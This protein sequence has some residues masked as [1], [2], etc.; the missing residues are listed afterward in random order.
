MAGSAIS[1]GG[2]GSFVNPV[3][4][5]YATSPTTAVPGWQTVPLDTVRFTTVSGMTDLTNHQIVITTSGLYEITWGAVANT[6]SMSSGS[7][8][9][10]N[11]AINGVLYPS[12]NEAN[13]QAGPTNT[14]GQSASAIVT[15]NAGDRISVMVYYNGTGSVQ[16]FSRLDVAK[17]DGTLS[18]ATPYTNPKVTTSSFAGGPPILPNDTDIWIATGVGGSACRWQFQYNASSSSSY[19]WEFI[20]GAPYA[21]VIYAV[22]KNT[23]AATWQN[24]GMSLVL[25][26]GGNYIAEVSVILENNT[27]G[28]SEAAATVMV[29]G[30]LQ[31]GGGDTNVVFNGGILTETG[32]VWLANVPAGATITD[33]YY[34]SVISGSGMI[35]VDRLITILPVNI[36]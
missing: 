11:L 31:T 6:V 4:S 29:N 36:G 18:T 5:M 27:G 9:F 35:F 16:V 26:R 28:T 32:P 14:P 3:A 23:V 21:A 8:L 25:P 17:V 10:I 1:F 15:V 34:T 22:F 2:G 13:L 30:T 20:G 33:A 24:G 12:I 19:K 7:E